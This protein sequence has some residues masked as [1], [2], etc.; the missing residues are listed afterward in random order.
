MPEFQ[1]VMPQCLVHLV[2]KTGA[3]SP[4]LYRILEKHP[5]VILERELFAF[6]IDHHLC[7]EQGFNI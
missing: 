3:F 2:E 1:S 4:K 6:Q 5:L 7:P